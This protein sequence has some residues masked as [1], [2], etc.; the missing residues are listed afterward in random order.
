MFEHFVDLMYFIFYYNKHNL[1]RVE[2]M[3]NHKQAS[4]IKFAHV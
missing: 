1:L 2:S 4:A 3:L